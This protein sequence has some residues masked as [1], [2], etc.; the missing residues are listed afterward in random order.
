VLSSQINRPDPVP[1]SGVPGIVWPAIPR[2]RDAG[3]F[4]LL[5]QLEMTQWWPSEAIARH[6]LRQ[7]TELVTFA[8]RNVPFYR[9]RLAPFADPSH[10]LTL[11]ELRRIPLL[12]RADI[13]RAGDE[14]TPDKPLGGHGK[15]Y[16]VTTSGSTGEPVVV[17]KDA[18]TK[19]LHSAFVLRNHLWHRRD[20]RG[21]V[22]T[23]R[24]V[25]D[26]IVKNTQAGGSVHWAEAYRSGETVFFDV[27]GTVEE[28]LKWVAAQDPEYLNIYPS[29]LRALIEAGDADGFKPAKLRQVSTF[30]EVVYSDLR[31]RCAESWHV[32]LVDLYSAQEVGFVALQ[33]PDAEGYHIQAE[34]NLVEIL[35]DEGCPS[36]P[37]ETGRVVVTTLHNF[38]TPLIRYELGDLAKVGAPCTCGRGLPVLDRIDGRTRNMFRLPDGS[39]F[40]L[41]LRPCGFEK[42][43]PVRQVQLIQKTIET[44]ELRIVPTRP[45]TAVEEA[46]AREAVYRVVPR[47]FNV[48]IRQVDEIPRSA[49]GKLEDIL[50]EVVD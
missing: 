38:A 9:E 22:A 49:G 29:F 45:L 43:A 3:T 23:V 37:G 48:V 47:S 31:A 40:G 20:F 46:R 13:Q 36:G 24:R 7:A 19:R 17:Q 33:C 18:V 15:S 6:Q 35:D 50:S 39:R 44:V 14:L 11:S 30:G 41:T 25:T 21:K 32:P 4:S 34:F 28:A 26:D 12:T 1:V 42:M 27:G 8:A 2:A 16:N 10:P 5:A